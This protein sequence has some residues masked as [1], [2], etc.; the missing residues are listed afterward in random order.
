MKRKLTIKELL[1]LFKEDKLNLGK[2]DKWSKEQCSTYI[3]RL[4]LRVKEDPFIVRATKKGY[5][6]IDGS[7]RINALVEVI[8]NEL[9]F[10]NLQ[11]Y[12]E[13]NNLTIRYMDEKHLNKLLN[14]E[15]YF[16]VM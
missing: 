8:E 10:N 11:Y 13:Y 12:T 6:V 3:E 1:G 5:E 14:S 7:D 16:N 9:K 15:I 4:M 2:Y